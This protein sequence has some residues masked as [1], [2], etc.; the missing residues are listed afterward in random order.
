VHIDAKALT[1]DVR[2]TADICVI[3]AG[4]A[5]ITIA[6]ELAGTSI[7]V[8][9]LE[10]GGFEYE[11]A[12]QALFEGESTGVPYFPLTVCRLRYFGGTTGHWQ[13]WCAPLDPLD[14]QE[15][16]WIPHSGWPLPY[17]DLAPW[18]E[19]AR[20]ICELQAAPSQTRY[21]ENWLASAA[22]GAKPSGTVSTK[23]IEFSPPTRFGTVY[24][25]EIVRA[26]NISLYTH[27]S[28]TSL[29]ANASGAHV[30]EAEASTL[31][32][33][34]LT[35]RANRFVLA[36]GGLENPR[37][38]LF[39]NQ[40]IPQGLANSHGVVG[41]YFMEHPHVNTS[42]MILAAKAY[43]SFLGQS[44]TFLPL[45]SI[46]PA[47][48]RQYK[49]ANYSTAVWPAQETTKAKQLW[50]FNARFEQTPN[51]DSRVTLSGTKRDAFG[52]PQ[53]SLHWALTEL[54]KHT[55]RT[56]ELLIAKELGRLQCGRLQIP[57][58]VMNERNEW[59]PSL[60]GAPHPMGTTRMSATAASGVVDTNCR[61]HEID[62]LYIAGS[63]VF[64]TAGA[65]NP[66]MTIVALAARLADHL[67]H[68][69]SS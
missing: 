8:V 9:L 28:V 60:S 50:T 66:T 55:L 5:G 56:A 35:V 51:P 42:N 59:P 10:S 45:I 69:V 32:P 38:L 57:D 1:S 44:H 49:I 17:D 31:G 62:N 18:Y 7:Q 16:S 3:G 20:V 24:R 11:E 12:T 65:A 14:F 47:A 52:K 43:A 53:L 4:A 19:K 36:C 13:G 27:A 48:Q 29:R 34:R 58:W 15:R 41:R 25:D 64:P 37:I 26:A 54:D 68:R 22:R 40:E 46:S 61:A 6:K 2:V 39:S 63:S 30:T 21:W 67:K 23:L 33:R